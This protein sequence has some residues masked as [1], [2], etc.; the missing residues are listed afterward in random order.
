MIAGLLHAPNAVR[1]NLQAFASEFLDVK[2]RS[3][4]EEILTEVSTIVR[5]QGGQTCREELGL[6]AT[7]T[8]LPPNVDL[9]T[10]DYKNPMKIAEHLKNVQKY[11]RLKN[12]YQF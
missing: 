9:R 8:V 2:N 6:I 4:I 7:K 10:Y 1:Q 3:D 11:R 12:K 5:L